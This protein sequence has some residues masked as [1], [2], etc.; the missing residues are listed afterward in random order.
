M[1]KFFRQIRYKLM[2]ENKTARYLKYA[3]GEIALVMIGILLA[4]QVNAWY[5]NSQDRKLENQILV[6]LKNSIAKDSM[7]IHRNLFNFKRIQKSAWYLDSVLTA[8]SD[9][10]Q[11]MDSAFGR[12][13][14]FT[15]TESDYVVFE[16][17]KSMKSGLISN[18]SLFTSL[19]NYY[20]FS[21]F[22]SGVDRYF[23]NGA[24]FR[25]A[26]YPKYFKH[27]RYGRYAQIADYKQLST[28]NEIRVA[29]DYCIN[30]A[31]YY[32]NR[33]QHRKEHAR[34]LI[35]MIEKELKRFGHD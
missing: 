21:K 2:S 11:K 26:I 9:Y 4:I 16:R 8:K 15:V 17:I 19:S 6:E 31:A 23:Q 29:I 12:I 1:I 18:D 34:E 22:L 13:S 5:Q 32:K 24:Y 35:E 33:T 25:Q 30:D 7:S 20:N 27:Y 3:I 14:A 10:H 28:S